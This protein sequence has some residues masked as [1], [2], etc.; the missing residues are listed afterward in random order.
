MSSWAESTTEVL[1]GY[2]RGDRKN[3][4]IVIP[5]DPV[6]FIPCTPAQNVTKKTQN[7][8][9]IYSDWKNHECK[10]AEN[11]VAELGHFFATA[12]KGQ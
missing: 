9:V 6:V 10:F 11:A 12:A 1:A 4:D 2:V 5:I 7:V 3:N 8:C